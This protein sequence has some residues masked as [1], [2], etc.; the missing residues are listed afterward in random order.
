M[1]CRSLS[2]SKLQRQ[3]ESPLH[4]GGINADVIGLRSLLMDL[5][6][7]NRAGPIDTDIAVWMHEAILVANDNRDDGLPEVKS[8]IVQQGGM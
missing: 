6:S 5:S 4:K 3:Y 2:L 7:L 8:R 1:I